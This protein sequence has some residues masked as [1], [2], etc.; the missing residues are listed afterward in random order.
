MNYTQFR[1][2]NGDE[3]VAQVIEEPEGDD[4]YIVVRN[5]MMIVRSENHTE[6]YRYYTFRPWMVCQQSES[7]YQLLNYNQIIGEAKPDDT[8][9]SQYYKAIIN[10]QT[11]VS[12]GNSI[13]SEEMEA[14]KKVIYET[15]ADSDSD[16][17]ISI[18]D[19]SK[20]H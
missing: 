9:L 3:I 18:F 13:T 20:L 8:L 6:G 15:Y 7:Y 2:A 14:L 4:F 5:A 10:E 16:N 17:V 11:E 12:E 1:L 19:K